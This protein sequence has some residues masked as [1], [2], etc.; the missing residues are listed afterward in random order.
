MDR[1]ALAEFLRGR[2]EQLQPGDVGLSVGVRRRAPGLR[3]EEVAQ[4]A[5]MSTDYYTRL[6]QQRGPQPSAQILS[7]LARALRLTAD[8]RDY[9]YRAAGHAVPDRITPSDHVAPPLQRVFDRLQDTPALIISNLGETLVQNALA[10]SLLGDNVGAAGFER[11][12]PYRWFVQPEQAR[13]HYPQDDHAR[14]SRAQV[15]GLRA[16]YGAMGAQSQAAM[17][18]AELTRRSAEFRDLWDKQEVAQRFA[19]HKTLIH[20]EVGPIEV[21]C[22]VLFT[23]DRGQALLVLTAAPRS[24]DEEKIRLLSVLGAQRFTADAR[25]RKG[26]AARVCSTPCRYRC[27]AIERMSG[28]NHC[29][30]PTSVRS[31]DIRT[32]ASPRASGRDGSAGV[33]LAGSGLQHV[34]GREHRNRNADVDRGL[35]RPPPLTGI[36]DATS[37]TVELGVL[38]QRGRR[39]V[40]QPR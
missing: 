15:A 31:P 37:Q 40:E 22:Q 7:S 38:M 36:R 39:E 5:L 27:R 32:A 8:E 28:R 25:A 23:E 16:A 2:R 14:N 10:A 20:P 9:L 11:Y 3:R 1:E 4:L 30:R 21:D 26:E 17:L 6:E 18:V 34:A 24:E 13:A 35:H 29:F 19:D 33:G 12:E